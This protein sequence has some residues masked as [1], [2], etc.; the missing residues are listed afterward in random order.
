M[1]PRQEDPR[2]VPSEKFACIKIQLRWKHTLDGRP[3]LDENARKIQDAWK[4]ARF[5]D[6]I[7]E[8]SQ[9]VAKEHQPAEAQLAEAAAGL[10]VRFRLGGGKIFYKIYTPPGDGH[11]LLRAQGLLRGEEAKAPRAGRRGLCDS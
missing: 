4:R 7:D 9:D 10:H 5:P 8:N 1:V 3:D 6:L 11:L 2:G